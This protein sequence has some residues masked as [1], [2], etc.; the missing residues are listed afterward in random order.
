[1]HRSRPDRRRR[2][3]AR[4]P[5]ARPGHREAHEHR[6]RQRGPGVPLRARNHRGDPRG[7]RRQVP[8]LRRLRVH[9]TRATRRPS[10]R[11]RRQRQRRVPRGARDDRPEPR[12]V[13]RE[14]RHE[15]QQAQRV[16]QVRLAG[17]QGKAKEADAADR[18]AAERKNAAKDCAR[19]RGTTE[20][21]RAAFGAQVPNV[22]EVR[23]ARDARLD[24]EKGGLV[25]ALFIPYRKGSRERMT[26]PE[27]RRRGDRPEVVTGRLRVRL[28]GG[29]F[30]V[31]KG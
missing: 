18:A 20:A 10:A 9:S 14:V 28:G 25:A 19:E 8:Q 26:V 5:S 21:S 31:S 27:M 6:P 29:V 16:R 23:L 24:N 11:T 12:R 22:R 1:M 30:G 15:R 3:D 17:R 2:H 7:V 4:R 13:R